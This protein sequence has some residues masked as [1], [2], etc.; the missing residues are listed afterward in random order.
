MVVYGVIS[1]TCVTSVMIKPM[2]EGGRGRRDV[3]K[4]LNTPL[5]PR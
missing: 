1:V 3:L 5:I 2:R 4:I